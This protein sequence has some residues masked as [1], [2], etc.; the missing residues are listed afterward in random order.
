M[1]NRGCKAWYVS[2]GAEGRYN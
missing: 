2:G 1:T